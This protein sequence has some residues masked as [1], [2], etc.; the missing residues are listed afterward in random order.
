M[1]RWKSR[2]R[3]KKW[4]KMKHKGWPKRSALFILKAS[5]Y[6]PLSF[7]RFASLQEKLSSQQTNEVENYSPSSDTPC[8]LKEY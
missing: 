2:N 1:S 8:H 6:P 7:G 3:K 5:L 4:R